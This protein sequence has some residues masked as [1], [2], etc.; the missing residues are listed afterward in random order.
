MTWIK[1]KLT[2]LLAM[3]LSQRTAVAVIVFILTRL[4]HVPDE[5]ADK[6]ATAL[7]T[8]LI[9][10]FAY[11]APGAAVPELAKATA[12][13]TPSMVNYK[14]MPAVT[15]GGVPQRPDPEDPR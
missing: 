3:A 1:G 12:A 5:L 10:S 8:V 6:I 7:A 2:A 15:P 14:S 9:A 4:L 13:P 11:R